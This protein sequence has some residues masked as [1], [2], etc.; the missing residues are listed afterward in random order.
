MSSNVECVADFFV[1]RVPRLSLE[2]FKQLPTTE[3][4]VVD[5]LTN[6]LASPEVEEAIYLASPSLVERIEQWREQ[7][8]SKTGQKVTTALLKYFIRMSSRPTPFGLFSGIS[9]GHF[10]DRSLITPANLQL[11]KRKTRLDM[12]YLATIQQQWAQSDAGQ[13]AVN[14]IPNTTLYQLGSFLH[15]IEP[16]QS[17]SQRQ[18]RLSSVEHDEA[19]HAMLQLADGGKSKQALIEQFCQLYPS[20]DQEDVE[21]YIQQLIQERVLMADLKLPLTSG[22]PDKAFVQALLNANN[23]DDGLVLQ[24]ALK[25]LDALDQQTVVKPEDYQAIVQHLKQLPYAVSENKLFQTDVKRTLQVAQLDTGLQTVLKKAVL[26]LQSQ[27]PVSENPL[28]NFITNFNQRFEGQAVPLLKLL[29]E[30][31]GISFSNDTGYET[32]LLAGINIANNLRSKTAEP[33]NSLS[34]KLLHKLNAN[35]KE[36]N[37]LQLSSDEM[38]KDAKSAELWQQM[39]ASFA[40]NISCYRDA[41]GER[42]I[43]LQGCT[44]PSGANLLGRFCHLDEALKQQVISH[45]EAEEALSKNAV[46][47]EVVH[48]PDGR[49]GNVIARPQLRQYEI[50]FLADTELADEKQISVQDLYA[51]VEGNEV[52]LWSKRLKK[53]VIPRLTSAHNY[54][55]RSLSIYH[56]LCMLQHQQ[57]ELPFYQSPTFIEQMDRQ[58][59][60]QL[61]NVILSEAK[62]RLERSLLE[63]L[64]KK[65]IWQENAWT[66]LKHRYQLPR[67]VCYAIHDNVLTIDLHNPVL[68]KILLAETKGQ[69][70]I[71]LKESLAMQYQSEVASEEGD[72]AHEVIV[73]ILNTKARPLDILFGE[74]DKM[75][76]MTMQR[77]FIPGSEWLSVK[78]YAAAST[79]ELLL[80]EAITDFLAFCKQ[81]GMLKQWFFI[82]Y[83]DPDWHLRL[84]MLG[85]PESLYS[86]VLPLLHNYLSEWVKS[87]R[88]RKVEIFTYQREIERYGG[89]RGIE[90]AE[91]V[92]QHDSEFV[93]QTVSL[94]QNYGESIR[95]R[96]ALLGVNAM[97]DAFSYSLD[98]KLEIMTQLRTAFGLEFKEHSHLRNQ[99][100]AKYRE[101]QKQIQADF[102]AEYK[103]AVEQP[104]QQMLIFQQQLIEKVRPLAK[105]ILAEQKQ[106]QLSCTTDNLLHSLLHMFCNRIFKTYGRE[107]EFV[108]YDFLRRLYLSEVA[109]QKASNSKLKSKVG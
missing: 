104:L 8:F 71:T 92:F 29:D 67:Y 21:A 78:I 1:V 105:Q 42:L 38:L 4:T 69:L 47:A 94:I 39:P 46:F 24:A 18:Y 80:N 41:S 96:M 10:T 86:K 33:E 95:T 20:V 58:P 72:F 40:A 84:R 55:D 5:Y 98:N 57:A 91:Q 13:Q 85:E 93:L 12:F 49:P 107:Q 63:A 68:V 81:Q 6:W 11:D 43:H 99:L 75:L 16:Y 28:I 70:Q 77:Q 103:Q 30:D 27:M 7:P 89:D 50:V 14:F 19:L 90:L 36:S 45:F 54:S 108:I 60:V 109:K 102:N 32:P 101:Y 25:K 2:Y 64:V 34:I 37:I 87:Q 97:L 17:S 51:F 65:D 59:R 66:E 26:A 31:V 22:Y 106:G 35:S 82:R 79:A 15:Y 56:F 88:V 3:K 53:L 83:S 62:W 44:G 9:L 48:M 76:D 73:P 23:T 100:G 74:P 61:D 52:K